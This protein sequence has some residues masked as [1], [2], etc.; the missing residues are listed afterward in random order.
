MSRTWT[1]NQNARPVVAIPSRHPPN[2]LQVRYHSDDRPSASPANQ[3]RSTKSTSSRARES[4]FSGFIRDK[5]RR[6]FFFMPYI[7]VNYCVRRARQYMFRRTTEYNLVPKCDCDSADSHASAPW[8]TPVVDDLPMC[9]AL[10]L[11][12]SPL[13]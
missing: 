8:R 6:P 7:S 5:D 9:T 1:S 11:S 13:R 10:K 3:L 4:E 12:A 2:S